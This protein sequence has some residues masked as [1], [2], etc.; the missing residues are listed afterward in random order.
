MPGKSGIAGHKGL[1]TSE[2]VG[3]AMGERLT[4]NLV[5]QPLLQAVTTRRLEKGL[6]HHSDRGSQ[7]CSH[8]YQGLLNQ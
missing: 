6:L 7:H 8:D 4:R 1:F 3:Y 2:I 5:N